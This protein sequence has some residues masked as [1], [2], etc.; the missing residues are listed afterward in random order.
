MSQP[1]A[2]PLALLFSTCALG[3][4]LTRARTTRD[5]GAANTPAA[6]TRS[7]LLAAHR[8][9]ACSAQKLAHGDED[10]LVVVR[11]RGAYL[12]DDAGA[13]YLDSRNNVASVG[14]Q[15]PDWVRAV[16][17]QTAATNTN[18]RYLSPVRARF[19][20]ALKRRLPRELSTVLLVNSG[21]EANELALRLAR[22]HTKRTRVVALE[23]GYH[24]VTNAALGAS[25]YKFAPGL[26]PPPSETTTI[27]L[28]FEDPAAAVSGGGLEPP[29]CILLEPALSAAGVVF[30]PEGWL[31]RAFAAVR[32]AGGVAIAD[33]VQVGLGRLGRTFFAFEAHGPGATPDILTLGKGLGNGFPVAAVACR[34]DIAESLAAEGREVFSTFGGNPVACAAGLAVLDI[35]EREGL[36]ERALVVGERV[37]DGARRVAAATAPLIRDVRGAGLFLGVEFAA[38]PVARA[39]SRRMLREHRVLTSLDGPEDRVMVVKPPMCWGEEEADAFV[40]ALGECAEWARDHH[41]Q[42]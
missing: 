30:P 11:G 23:G 29:A 27:S 34:R 22:A 19:V 40:R 18:A 24:G 9:D 28:A 17:E 8:R 37:A 10:V 12:F 39:V 13:A 6:P 36:Q 41:P 38:A 14:H 26:A 20:A 25:P 35:I 32:A 31:A 16:C 4:A 5:E 21:S 33:E 1:S 2:L 42:Q 15:H 3:A 7:E